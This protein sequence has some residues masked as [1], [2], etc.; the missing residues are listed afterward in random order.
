MMVWLV[1][2]RCGGTDR[3]YRDRV[4]CSRVTVGIVRRNEKG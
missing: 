1:F 2:G 4:L 3:E